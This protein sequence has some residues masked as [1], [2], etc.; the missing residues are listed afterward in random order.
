MN[1]G[2]ERHEREAREQRLV[3]GEVATA[4]DAYRPSYPDALF[5]TI[6]DF[7]GLKAGEC[8]LEIGAGT[9]K[10]TVAFLRRGLTVHALEPT[11][12]MAAVARSKGIDVEESLFEAWTP[13]QSFDLVYAAQA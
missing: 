11:R 13:Q 6:V 7:G 8:A 4:Y 3:F 2:A 1:P 5:D 10:A 12:E 9:G